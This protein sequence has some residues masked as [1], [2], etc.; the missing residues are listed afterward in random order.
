MYF[1]NYTVINTIVYNLT[2]HLGGK[3]VSMTHILLFANITGPDNYTVFVNELVPQQETQG[4]LSIIGYHSHEY[5]TG[6]LGWM[7]PGAP[8]SVPPMKKPTACA[9]IGYASDY[10]TPFELWIL[11]PI[12]TQF[13]FALWGERDKFV[14]VSPQRFSALSLTSQALDVTV[15]LAA[16]IYIYVCTR[17]LFCF[18]EKCFMLMK[19]A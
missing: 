1:S 16:G 19:A 6:K 17:T 10:C 15:T 12:H 2:H 13:P 5:Y 18:D 14:P 9:K 3:T 11:T 7:G 8:L 4:T